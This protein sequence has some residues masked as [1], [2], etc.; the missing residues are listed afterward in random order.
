[1]SEPQKVTQPVKA[2]VRHCGRLAHLT[3]E[4]PDEI[5]K[6]WG[7]KPQQQATVSIITAGGKKQLIYDFGGA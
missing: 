2:T 5:V 7:L 3:I 1:M 4:L 6:Q